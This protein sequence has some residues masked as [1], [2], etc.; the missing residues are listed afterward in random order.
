MRPQLK[1]SSRA[2]NV[3]GRSLFQGRTLER[4]EALD[5]P[6]KRHL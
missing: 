5:E 1:H 2:I 6:N 3:A 4:W